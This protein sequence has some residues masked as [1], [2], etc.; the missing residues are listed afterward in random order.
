MGG[1]FRPGWFF[2]GLFGCLASLFTVGCT[3]LSRPPLVGVILW[4]SEIP[5]FSENLQGIVEGLRE[6]GYQDGV[7]LRLEV[8]DVHGQRDEA[9]AA[10]RRF[11]EAGARVLLTVGTIPTL[12]ALE[13][14]RDSRLPLVYSMVAT[15]EDSGLKWPE[16]PR[17]TRFTGASSRVPAREQ[18][19]FLL[20]IKPGLR[21]LG[22]LYC[23]A[24][25]QAVATGRALLAGARHL[26]L[27]GCEENVPDG[28]LELLQQ[29]LVKLQGA[30]VEAVCLPAD[31]VLLA[32]EPLRVICETLHRAGVPVLASSGAAVAAGALLAYHADFAD[33]GRQVGRQAARLLRGE[34]PGDVP[35]EDPLVKQLSINVKAARDLGLPIPWQLLGRAHQ[36]HYQGL[37]EK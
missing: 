16:D 11:Q 10:A 13:V 2:W 15:P 27:H 37:P 25:P 5:I 19:Q 14:T 6:E 29:A 1:N 26:G 23:T 30:G 31:P 35:P 33:I 9:A 20:S 18:L 32:R 22:V 24:T 3:L 7:N 17:E 34:R 8:A 28:R 36:I 4:S 21:R 12:V